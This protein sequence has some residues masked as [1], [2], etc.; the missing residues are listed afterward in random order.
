MNGL[1]T[2]LMSNATLGVDFWSL[3]LPRLI[4]GV[5]MGCIFVPLQ[6]LAF[7]SVP[8]GTCPTRRRSSAWSAMSA[9]APGSPSRPRSSAGAP[10]LHQS[11]LVANVHVWDPETAERLR[12][13]DAAFPGARSRHRSRPGQQAMAMLYRETQAQAQVLAFMDD[14]RV[15][16]V[17]YAGLVLLVF[18]MHRVRP[19]PAASAPSPPRARPRRPRRVSPRQARGVRR[20]QERDVE[21]GPDARRRG[22]A[23]A[24]RYLPYVR[25]PSPP[26]PTKQ[27]GPYPRPAR[28]RS[29]QAASRRPP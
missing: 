27:M 29:S 3:A 4:Q 21:K 16:A 26:P 17:M 25:A 1:A 6:M 18:L 23:G 13:V 9:A 28:Q 24:R 20:A 7:A 19:T 8:I 14:F 11:A 22:R 12:P 2:Y 5:G 10:R 15:L